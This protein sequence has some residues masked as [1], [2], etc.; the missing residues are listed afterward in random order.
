VA[1][2]SSLLIGGVFLDERK[3]VKD[4]NK[5][6]Q[7]LRSPKILQEYSEGVQKSG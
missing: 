2:I 6:T 5:K 7:K 1:I 4:K 3:G